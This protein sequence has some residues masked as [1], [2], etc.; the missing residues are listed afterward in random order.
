MRRATSRVD[1]GLLPSQR[2]SSSTLLKEREPPLK[3]KPPSSRR[4]GSSTS[5]YIICAQVIHAHAAKGRHT[6]HIIEAV[7]ILRRFADLSTV[8]EDAR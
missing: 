6:Q 7:E 5:A 8:E 4:R 1:T 2:A 3:T